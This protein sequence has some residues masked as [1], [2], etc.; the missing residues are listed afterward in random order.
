MKKNNLMA[1]V[2]GLVNS[3]KKDLDFNSMIDRSVDIFED[4]MVQLK[5]GSM[6]DKQKLIKEISNANDKINT[7]VDK[8]CQENG[9]SRS[10]MEELVKTPGFFKNEEFEAM[11][12]L[13]K[14]MKSKGKE[15]GVKVT[16]ER[17]KKP[18]RKKGK[19]KKQWL[20]A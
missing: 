15:F 19:N 11:Q 20:S 17:E 14:Q 8:V 13:K 18:K 2:D 7:Y 4:V 12:E 9:I 10:E 3:D 16:N 6:E 5:E 1:F